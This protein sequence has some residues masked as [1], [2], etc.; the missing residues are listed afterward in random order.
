MHLNDK[1]WDGLQTIAVRG[2]FADGRVRRDFPTDTDALVFAVGR[3][4]HGDVSVVWE[5]ELHA[6][7]RRGDYT[8]RMGRALIPG[9]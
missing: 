1:D 4:Y 8:R 3:S 6:M 5:D 9:L 2:V 7:V